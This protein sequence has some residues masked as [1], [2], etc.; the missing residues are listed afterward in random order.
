MSSPVWCHVPGPGVLVLIAMSEDVTPGRNSISIM[1]LS[2]TTR[3]KS[4]VLVNN[5]DVA[6]KGTEEGRGEGAGRGLP[7][8]GTLLAGK[9]R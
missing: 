1:G 8:S 9:G 2:L 4:W 5:S 3:R 7:C 6:E